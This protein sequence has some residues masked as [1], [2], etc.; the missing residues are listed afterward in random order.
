M[1]YLEIAG[2]LVGILYLWLEYNASIYL[3]IASL[4][5]PAIYVFV[6]YD[7]GLYAD[8]GISIYYILASV[9]GLVVWSMKRKGK[10]E[11]PTE[12][13]IIHTPRNLYFPLLLTA[14]LLTIGIAQLLIHCTDSTVPWADSF[15]TALSIV[16]MWMLAKKHLEQWLV[17]LIVDIVS[18]ILYIYKGLY[19]TAGLYLFYTII[20]YLGYKK[21]KQLM[22]LQP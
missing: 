21:W 9:Y 8:L 19:F 22:S 3:W 4:V 7:A 17:W 11:G 12:R 16:A 18:S 10:E 1:N 20:V 13:P 5:M 6:Y 2:T 14:V 15:T